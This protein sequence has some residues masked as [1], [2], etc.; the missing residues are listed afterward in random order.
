MLRGGEYDQAY[1]IDE[2]GTPTP[3]GTEVLLQPGEVAFV[4]PTIGDIH[5][6]RNAHSDQVSIGI[7][8]YGGDIGKIDRHVFPDQGG[9]RKD[10][11]S[12]YSN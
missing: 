8:V 7:H 5:L 12:S 6:V 9:A 1:V 4:S 10:F 3:Q 2:D 11:I